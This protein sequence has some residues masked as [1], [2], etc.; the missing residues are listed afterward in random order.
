MEGKLSL[1]GSFAGGLLWCDGFLAGKR[2]LS[3][4]FLDLDNQSIL[5]ST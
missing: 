5:L 2:A 4:R 3:H 1:D